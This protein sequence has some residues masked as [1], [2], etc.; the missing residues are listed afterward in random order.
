MG[1]RVPP[2]Q[3]SG[4]GVR[5]CS[6]SRGGPGR[7]QEAS[8]LVATRYGSKP[9]F[10]LRPRYPPVASGR[11]H[12]LSPGAS[13]QGSLVPRETLG[14]VCATGMVAAGVWVV[15]ASSGQSPVTSCRGQDLALHKELCSPECQPLVVLS[16][17]ERHPDTSRLRVRSLVG[18]Y[19]S[20]GLRNPSVGG[21]VLEDNLWG[22]LTLRERRAGHPG[23][24]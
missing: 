7:S 22:P 12:F 1:P 9:R 16:W 23:L 10:R 24:R 13:H 20:A 18:T 14:S 2:V 17:L 21:R 3:W 4:P 15:L 11:P 5:G 19:K 8:A 6:P